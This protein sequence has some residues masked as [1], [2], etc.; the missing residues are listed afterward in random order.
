MSAVPGSPLPHLLGSLDPQHPNQEGSSSPNFKADP[1]GLTALA[2]SL[3]VATQA[4]ICF[5]SAHLLSQLPVE[6]PPSQGFSYGPFSEVKAFV[7][8]WCPTLC[9]PVDRGPLGALVHG[10][11]QARI[12]EGIAIP[13]S[14]GSS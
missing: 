13:S 1:E 11:L 9:D 3:S 2:K 7:A 12:L 14:R 10:I 4:L 5:L 6:Q 8:Q